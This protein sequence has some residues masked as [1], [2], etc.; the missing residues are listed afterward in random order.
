MFGRIVG[1][2][3][4][5]I[6]V[7]FNASAQQSFQR[8][9]STNQFERALAAVDAIKRRKKLQC[10]MSIANGKLCEC[11]SQKLPV[12]TYV[13][14]YASVVSL[15]REGIEYGQLSAPD[16]AIVDQCVSDHPYLP[17]VYLPQVDPKSTGNDGPQSK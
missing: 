1:I 11:L 14:S 7:S 2:L 15:G 4:V 8:Y 5:A 17:Q 12:D 6:V 9:E 3:V 16:K 10:V 13:R